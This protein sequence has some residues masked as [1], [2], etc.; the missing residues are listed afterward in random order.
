MNW[1]ESESTKDS[2]DKITV[3]RTKIKRETVTPI[4]AVTDTKREVTA[5]LTLA[6]KLSVTVK[7]AFRVTVTLRVK[8]TTTVTETVAETV[9]DTV[10]DTVTTTKIFLLSIYCW[11]LY[12][13]RDGNHSECSPNFPRALIIRKTHAITQCGKE[14]S[15]P[16]QPSLR[17]HR[18]DEWPTSWKMSE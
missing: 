9:T 4:V 13:R 2:Y 3:A 6:L 11:I 1:S 10:T 18:A 12:Q 17:L 7:L 14:K 8:E 5:T 16:I 15:T